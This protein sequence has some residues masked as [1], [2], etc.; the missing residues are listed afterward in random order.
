MLLT[1]ARRPVE[2][3]AGVGVDVERGDPVCGER[4]TASKSC[5]CW[6]SFLNQ[7]S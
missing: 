6:P 5:G 3:D 7:S 1:A 4:R 2:I